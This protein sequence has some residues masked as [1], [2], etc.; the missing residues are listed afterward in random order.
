VSRS[1]ANRPPGVGY[2]AYPAAM[3]TDREFT[4]LPTAAR[5]IYFAICKQHRHAGKR[6]ESNNGRIP[7][8]CAAAAKATGIS[9]MHASRMLNLLRAGGWLYLRKA[10]EMRSHPEATG[11]AAEWEVAIF[12]MSRR[13]R[14][15]YGGARKLRV[16]HPVVESPAYLR[17]TN[18][19]KIV[20]FEMMRRFKG[21]N[22]GRIGFDGKDGAYAGLTPWI[23]RA[24]LRQLEAERFIAETAR[25]RRRRIWRLTML[26]T[27]RTGA[28]MDFLKPA[29]R[30]LQQRETPDNITL[31]NVY[32]PQA[33]PAHDS[34]IAANSAE[35]RQKTPDLP[36]E[37][38]PDDALLY[39][40]P[41]ET[42]CTPE[43]AGSPLPAP[44]SS[45]TPSRA[46]IQPLFF[47]RPELAKI[48]EPAESRHLTA[49]PRLRRVE[50]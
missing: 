5:A 26:K 12:P 3:L 7:F 40:I 15:R 27:G 2:T 44:P 29:E 22:N 14:K 50:Q 36:A 9:T 45:P 18:T 11:L 47:E 17:L 21:G 48:A 4:A 38:A 30:N 43:R 35:L 6:S 49:R 8:G 25:L 28:T 42:S 39:V 34:P 23:T 37:T 32:I 19:A 16:E 33:A 13:T 10:G 46:P 31:N 1:S 41:I 24:A 20:L